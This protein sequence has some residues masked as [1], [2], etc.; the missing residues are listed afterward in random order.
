MQRAEKNRLTRA[1]PPHPL[2]HCIGY[3]ITGRRG[4]KAQAML[5]FIQR[6]WRE[7]VPE[8]RRA[9]PFELKTKVHTTAFAA[10][11]CPNTEIT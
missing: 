3:E 7:L 2:G 10:V 6:R 4:N 9:C 1:N 11:Y 5:L 8:D